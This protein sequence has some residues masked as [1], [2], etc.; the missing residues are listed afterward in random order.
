MSIAHTAPVPARARRRASLARWITGAAVGAALPN[1]VD[2]QAYALERALDGFAGVHGADDGFE[3]DLYQAE[4]NTALDDLA[5]QA[6]DFRS[7]GPEVQ[8]AFW[9]GYETGLTAA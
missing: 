3:V 8:Q 1:Q 9:D 6:E 2:D 7:Q 4:L 5:S